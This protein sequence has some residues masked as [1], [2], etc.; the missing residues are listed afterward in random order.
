MKRYDMIPNEVLK[1][2]VVAY[3]ENPKTDFTS[4]K[5]KLNQADLK[6]Q[7]IKENTRKKVKE[8][9]LCIQKNNRKKTLQWKLP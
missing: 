9:D 8:F 3:C 6:M 7:Q 1:E 2:F 4:E 5:D